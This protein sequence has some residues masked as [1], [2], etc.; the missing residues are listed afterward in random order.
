MFLQ[1][2][3]FK[4]IEKKK[5]G[6][7]IMIGYILLVTIALVM[8]AII[9]AWVKTYVPTETLECPDGSSIFIKD[10]EYDCAGS[11]N[12]TLKNNGRFNLAGYFIHAS[13]VSEQELE[14]IDL[15]DYFNSSEPAE[16]MSLYPNTGIKFHS[17]GE[18]TLPPNNEVR[19]I[20]NL[21]GAPFG[22]LYSIEVVAFRYQTDG[23]KKRLV[24]CSESA[25][26]YRLTC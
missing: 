5:K 7:S 2:K 15:T 17:T 16:A 8:A 22:I 1:V 14:T 19:H 24:S 13:N 4:K 25:V 26:N 10:I 12:L 3:F 9:Y 23:S 18:N 6:I 21:S 20:Y 11:L